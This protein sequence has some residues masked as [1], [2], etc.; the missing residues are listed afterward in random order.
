MICRPIPVGARL[1]DSVTLVTAPIALRLKDE[2]IDGCVQYLGS[3]TPEI[4]NGILNAGLGLLLVT[5]ADAFDGKVAGARAKALRYP[6]GATV[7]LD[8]EGL[9]TLHT[10]TGLF[11]SEIDNWSKD[12][13]AEGGF[14]PGIYTGVPQ[15]LTSTELFLRRPVRYWKGQGSLRDRFNAL[16]EPACGW[17]MTQ[18]YPTV[19][20]GGIE[21]DF[22]VVG[23]DF[24][25]RVPSWAIAA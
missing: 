24:E 23:A 18:M 20:R 12:V 1:T 21:V 17:C 16:V 10:E 13:E 19:V 14:M 5:Y 7:F 3:V 11:E 8:I 25:G 22:N 9:E 15:P 2:G 4:A 6:A